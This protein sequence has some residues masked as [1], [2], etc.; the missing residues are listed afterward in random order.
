MLDRF[1]SFWTSLRLTVVCLA[2]SIVL[3]FV[4]TIAQA[5][6][7]LYQTQERYFKHW[8]VWGFS[9]FG[10][11]VPLPLPGGYLLGTIL[12]VNLTAAHIK[13]FHLTWKKL[14][15]HLTH[16]GIILLLV[17]QLATDLFSRETQMRFSE[18]ETKWYSEDPRD[19]ELAVVQIQDGNSEKVVAIPQMLLV[20]GSTIKHPELPFDIRIESY[21]P[22]SEPAYRAPMSANTPAVT[23]NGIAQS[24]DF[25]E[26]PLTKTMEDKNVPTAVIEIQKDGS[27]YGRWVASGWAGDDAMVAGVRIFWI[28]QLGQ[29]P[30]SR[31]V[32]QLTE[33]QVVS[34]DGRSYRVSL[35]P[36]RHYE[37]YSMTLLQRT[38]E[39]YPGTTIPKNFQSR[40][41]IENPERNERRE[42]DIYMNNPLRYGGLTFYQHQMSPE[43]IAAFERSSTLQVVRNPSWLTP[44]IGCLLV[45]AGLVVQ[46]MTHLIQFIKRRTA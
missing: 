9:F 18:G 46:F 22:N 1:I 16:G 20:T 37:P 7:G 10:K 14:G 44:Y 39:V 42:V 3:V 30:A 40:V 36:V 43:E 21:W 25:R 23:T 24:F 27:S 26:V 17:G 19:Y 33:P 32:A 8:L 41:E 28:K 2:F 38:H 15:I 6:E 31:M 5:D 11:N 13:R 12:L 4:G 34:V 29:Q 45:G 35:R